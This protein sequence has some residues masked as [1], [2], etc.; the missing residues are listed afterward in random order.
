MSHRRIARARLSALVSWLAA[1]AAVAVVGFG[2]LR[3]SE[4]RLRPYYVIEGQSFGDID[5]RVLFVLDTS[6]SM[7]LS[8]QA[9]EAA[10]EWHWCETT[11]GSTTA[12]RMATA[13]AAIHSVVASVGDGASFAMM[14]FGQ[15]Q[16]RVAGGPLPEAPIHCEEGT[17]T[18]RRFTWVTGFR[19]AFGAYG[20]IRQHPDFIGAWRL[21][22]G[23]TKAPYPYLRWDN[24]GV[25]SVITSQVQTDAVPASPL[26]STDA[27]DFWDDANSQRRVQWFPF[28]MGTRVN[29][30]DTTD[31]DHRLT[32]LTTGDYGYGTSPAAEAYKDAE[33]RGHDFYYW[34]YVDG[35]PGYSQWSVSPE[36]DSPGQNRAGVIGNDAP[37]ASA[38]LYAPFYI[39]LSDTAIDPT[40]WGPSTLEAGNTSVLQYSSPL[41]E[42]GVDAVGPTPWRSAIG[43]VT[44]TP[45]QNNSAFSHTTVA[46]YL[47]FATSVESPDVCAP[48]YAVLVTDGEPSGGEGGGDLYRR[49][50][51][52][53]VELGVRTFVVGLFLDGSTAVNDM[54]CAAAGACSGSSCSTPCADTP[55]RDWDTCADPDSPTSACAYQ[56][57]DSDELAQ[58]LTTIVNS[59][60]ELELVS[61]PG[62]TINDFGVGA[63]GD[64]GEGQILQTDFVAYTEF[65][66]WQG[67]VVRSLC[68]DVDGDGN[69]LSHCVLPDPEFAPEDVEESFGPCAQSH[70]WD[71][72][73]CL[74]LTPWSERRLFT[75]TADRGVIAIANADG[76]AS[77][78]FQSEL[79][80]LGLLTSA[81]H[82]AEADAIAAFLLGRDAPE[83]WKLAGVANSAPVVVRRIPP[84]RTDRSPEVAIRDPHCAGR[85]Y[86]DLD[87]GS[88]PP[89][90]V[91]FATQSNDET[92]LL[93]SPSPHHEYQEAVMI[94]DDMGV[95]HA[96]QLDSGNE[97]W[98]YV[99]RD[100]LA[101][102]VAQSAHGAVGMG[103]PDELEDHIYGIA[104]TLNHGWSYDAVNSRWV[105][106]GVLGFGAGGH[107]YYALD[108]SH[109]SPASDEGPFELLWTTQ[110]E[111]LA[112]QYDELLGQTWARPALSY[113]VPNEALTA[114]PLS[115]LVLGSGYPTGPAA[116]SGQGRT[117][118]LA[119]GTT[120]EIVEAA[121]LPDLSEPVF[122]SSFGALVDPAVASHCLSRFWAEMQETYVAD[123]AGRLF[124]WD[125]GRDSSHEADSG[126]VWGTAA[127]QVARF[128]ACEGTGVECTVDGGNRGDVFIYPPAV[129]ASNRIDDFTAVAAGTA[130][131]ERD[132]FLIALASGSAYEDTID[133]GAENSSFHSSI[134]LLVD[135]HRL[136]DKHL[137]FSIPDGAPKLEAGDATGGTAFGDDGKYL[138]LALSDILRTR[139]IVP[140]D[141]AGEIVETRAFSKKARPLRAP[142]IYVTGVVDR[143]D[144]LPDVVIEGIEVY[145]VEFTIYEPGSGECDPRFYDASNQTWHF[146]R[147]S[148]YTLTF[149]LTADLATGFNFTSGTTSGAADFGAGFTTGLALGSVT[150]I[151]SPECPSGDCGPSF[152]SSASVP[153]DNNVAAPDPGSYGFAVPTTSLQVAGFTPV[154]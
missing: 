66:G 92:E 6:G 17:D 85:L 74:R 23:G 36:V 64:A 42:G 58:V 116:P 45:D 143:E 120:G 27:T 19:Q 31:L 147:G 78:A 83:G 132:Q 52:L 105:H 135:D 71:A 8:N 87:G 98:G 77:G 113:R 26:I 95:L 89:S 76:S 117:L 70:Q 47:S 153:C 41:I 133:G 108:L 1:I 21:C 119:N 2:L 37:T 46:S 154:E 118:I 9:A 142:R 63:N 4:A 18:E 16:P 138:R 139:T 7:G 35:F 86:G 14:T 73:E 53:R 40:L 103:Q 54:A 107:E 65:P 99:P 5:P 13:R 48:V 128:P 106:L 60:L 67:H 68:D 29:L 75:N 15:N 141:G 88:L 137:G 25:G 69:L 101:N 126:D 84:Y 11:V 57:A 112:D 79:E 59:A 72:G 134:Y 91:Q 97:L 20:D 145:N 34:P 94:G 49:L 149:T 44:T 80:G 109:M 51:D 82:D 30:N 151:Q 93:Q 121:E 150:Q 24:L 130:V 111:A 131:D 100:L 12:S 56:A 38:Q 110:D 32:Y 104:A 39:D 129:T 50:A 123:P 115:Y 136:G 122:E 28:Y 146:D 140:F 124:R 125:L 114:E 55:S 22:Q 90:L 148:T 62:A 3:P 96:F 10:C 81:D 152:D 33:V 61:G 144:G 43:P 127:Q 102:A